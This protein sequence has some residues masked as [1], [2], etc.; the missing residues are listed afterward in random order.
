M[1]SVFEK[2]YGQK[3][4][5]MDSTKPSTISSVVAESVM[6]SVSVTCRAAGRSSSL[7]GSELRTFVLDEKEPDWLRLPRVNG[8][9][10][11][12]SLPESIKD[13]ISF[14]RMEDKIRRCNLQIAPNPFAKG[15]FSL[16]WKNL[17]FA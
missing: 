11:S 7:R 14:E 2:Y 6:K 16:L 5:K 4:S 12:F 15:S 17:L 13:I 10:L 1:I 8:T 3:I 9:I